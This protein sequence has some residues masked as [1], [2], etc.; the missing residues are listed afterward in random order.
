MTAP[1]PLWLFHTILSHMNPC[2]D[3][4]IN[5]N[6]HTLTTKAPATLMLMGEHAVLRGAAALVMAVNY[7]LCVTLSHPSSFGCD[8]TPDI[9]IHSK[10]CVFKGSLVQLSQEPRLK[11]VYSALQYF[12]EDLQKNLLYPLSLTIE[13]NFESTWGLGSSAAVLV[14]TLGGLW[15]WIKGAPAT[16]VILFDNALALLHQ[17]QGRGSGAD[18]AG[19]IWGGILHYQVNPRVI[20]P[21]AIPDALHTTPL[22][23]IYCGYKTPTP[24]VI[25]KVQAEFDKDPLRYARIYADIHHAATQGIQALKAHHLPA[26]YQ[27]I[28]HNQALMVELGVSDSMLDLILQRLNTHAPSIPGKISGSGLGDCVIAFGTVDPTLFSDLPQIVCLPM[29]FNTQGVQYEYLHP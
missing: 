3:L 25:R 28:A 22:T 17:T 23:A 29:T 15:H 21:L 13:S 6:P 2:E 26:F 11:F 12:K 16:P 18:L 14:A 27:A 10:L 9:Q 19:T 8:P 1:L 20:E 4:T 5:P 7:S 24:V